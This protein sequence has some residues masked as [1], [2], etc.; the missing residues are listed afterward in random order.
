MRPSDPPQMSASRHGTGCHARPRV[1]SKE[2]LAEAPG[3]PATTAPRLVPGTDERRPARAKYRCRVASVGGPGVGGRTVWRR[4]GAQHGGIQTPPRLA[5]G[6]YSAAMALFLAPIV[7]FLRY[8]TVRPA[9]EVSL[10]R[11]RRHHAPRS[12]IA[13]CAVRPCCH[14]D[15]AGPRSI[16]S[17]RA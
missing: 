12:V 16:A 15:A 14:S 1:A 9:A 10:A 4:I 6:P 11:H 17:A 5:E 8:V 3:R 2:R 7:R 13:A